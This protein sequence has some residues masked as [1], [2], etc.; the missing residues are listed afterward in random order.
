MLAICPVSDLPVELGARSSRR[1]RPSHQ[2]HL[3][4]KPAQILTIN[5]TCSAAGACL[6]DGG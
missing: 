4:R 1:T 6:A 2:S 5:D 3:H